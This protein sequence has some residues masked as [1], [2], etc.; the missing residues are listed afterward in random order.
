MGKEDTS[1]QKEQEEPVLISDGEELNRYVAGVLSEKAK[2]AKRYRRCSYTLRLLIIIFGGATTVLTQTDLPRVVAAI[3]S[4]IVIILASSL[5]IFKF[6]E[7]NL[8]AIKLFGEINTELGK[9]AD[10]EEP[11]NTKDG[12]EGMRIFRRNYNRLV[13]NYQLNEAV[14]LNQGTEKT[15]RTP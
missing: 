5:G 14:L 11:Y 7:R 3:T 15:I 9:F 4:A 12:I 10:G 8:S 6:E 1:S 2:E 13:Q